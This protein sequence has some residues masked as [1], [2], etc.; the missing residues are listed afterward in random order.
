GAGHGRLRGHRPG[1]RR[2]HDGVRG[3]R[4]PLRPAQP[5]GGRRRGRRPTVPAD[6]QPPGR[7]RAGARGTP[8]AGRAR[9]RD[10]AARRRRAGVAAT[11]S[12]Q[13]ALT[14]RVEI[15]HKPG[16]LGLV[17]SAIG[18]A[19]GTIGSVD[20]VGVDDAY[21]LR[22]ITVD[23]SGPEQWDAIVAAIDAVSAARVID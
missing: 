18:A 9:A 17:A 3:P 22:D 6:D 1:G 20:L 14:I 12:A 21:T 4:Q 5:D 2:A 13:Y 10:P 8:A 19:G 16:M 15:E 7:R 23:A 11:P